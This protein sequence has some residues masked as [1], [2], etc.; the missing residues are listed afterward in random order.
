M[1]DIGFSELV[2]VFVIGLI[3][4]GPQR[5]PVAV[6]TVVGWIRAIRSLAANV[7]HELAQEL[8]LQEL[9]ESLK[10]VEEAGRGTLSP[11]LKESM[12][13]LRKTADSMKRS[14]SQS[15][16]I[17]KE[18]DEANTI[19]SAQHRPV[20]HAASD[21]VQAS[22]PAVAEPSVTPAS[23]AHQAS[24]AAQSP[25]SASGSA[26]QPSA[27]PAAVATSPAQAPSAVSSAPAVQSSAAP[28]TAASAPAQAP[29]GDAAR[30]SAPSSSAS[31]ER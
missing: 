15:I 29:A 26:V 30:H 8:K 2:L 31:D 28:A 18:E 20:P 24:A 23:A 12:E 1:F 4:L 6:K 13:E 11:E 22:E 21:A 19:H 7:Q 14:V 5:L 17:E 3:V 16:D 25:S 10:K 27:A 9:Q